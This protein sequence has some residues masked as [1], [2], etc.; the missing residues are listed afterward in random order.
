M[1]RLN[2][3]TNNPFKQGDIREDG[4]VFLSYQYKK[5]KKNGFFVEA[6]VKPDVYKAN[7]IKYKEATRKYH[8]KIR[9]NPKV[10][11]RLLYHS[12]KHR[13]KKSNATISITPEW[14]LEK[15][16]NGFCE[17][18]GLPFDISLEKTTGKNPFAPSLDRINPKNRNYEPSNVRVILQ[19]LN[20]A[21]SE[22]GIEH[23]IKIV[24]AM[25]AKLI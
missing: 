21:L 9:D 16:N 4:Y 6:W 13:A 10:R 3:L 14:I 1:K 2:S 11:A 22:Y 19:S 8:A 20:M 17:L 18:S 5:I 15:I 12:A 7:L 24:D 25:K 23:L